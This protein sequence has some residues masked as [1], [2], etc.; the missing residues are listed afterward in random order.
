MKSQTPKVLHTLLGKPVVAYVIAA[1]QKARV[2]RILLVVGHRSDLVRETFGPDYEYVEQTQQLGTGHALMMVSQT[3]KTFRGDLLVL[4]GD[5]P[6]LTGQIL[7]KLIQHHKKTGAAAT[8]MTAFIDPPP[9]YGRIVR[10]ASGRILRIVEEKDASAAEKKIT[11]VNTSHYI[12]KTEAV[13]PLLSRLSAENAQGEYYL[14]D[15]IQLLVQD[16]NR[17]ETLTAHDPNV[18]IGINSRIDLSRAAQTLQEKIT[19]KHMQNGVTIV[20]PSSVYIEPDVKIGTDTVVHPFCF[21]TGK[22]SV[23]KRCVIG[24][25]VKLVDA[26]IGD[27]CAVEFSVIKRRKIENGAAIGPFASIES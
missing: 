19:Q 22:T 12:F 1:C 3:L 15:I 6:F 27:G 8:L 9:A 25:Q 14:T 5:T 24:P 17:V 7:R 18:L 10:D 20:H 26:K 2:D 4:A 13:F 11:E 16:S 21:L 23:G